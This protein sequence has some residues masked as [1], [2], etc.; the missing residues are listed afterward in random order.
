M[1]N[2]LTTI[3]TIDFMPTASQDKLK[4]MV[5]IEYHDY[6]HVFNPEAPMKQLQSHALHM[7]LQLNLTLQNCCQNLQDPII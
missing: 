5:P 6:L 3:Y 2:E 7:I 1:T 4:S